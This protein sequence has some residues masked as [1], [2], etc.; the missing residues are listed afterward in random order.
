MCIYPFLPFLRSFSIHLIYP[1]IQPECPLNLRIRAHCAAIYYLPY[2]CMCI[3]INIGNLNFLNNF[4]ER[5][6]LSNKYIKTDIIDAPLLLCGE[7]SETIGHYHLTS[8]FVLI[9][10]LCSNGTSHHFYL[11]L[12]SHL[13]MI[14]P[15]V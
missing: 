15:C 6:N 14:K 1:H 4:R 5:V 13:F 10:K 8:I 9:L 7:W 11:E 3:Q 2:L 12:S